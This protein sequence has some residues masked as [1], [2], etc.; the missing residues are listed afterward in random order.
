MELIVSV[1][2]S[3][4]LIFVSSPGNPNEPRLR[5]HGRRDIDFAFHKKR[6]IVA[7][8]WRGR[9]RVHG[10]NLA[11]EDKKVRTK[12]A[13]AKKEVVERGQGAS[14]SR[15]SIHRGMRAEVRYERKSIKARSTHAW[16]KL[17]GHESDMASKGRRDGS[18]EWRERCWLNTYIYSGPG[19]IR[20]NTG[21]QRKREEKG[22]KRKKMV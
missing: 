8:N 6:S 7:T 14:W 4:F 10:G 18:E 11:E 3:S 19:A 13:K 22:R 12:G 5:Y 15:G 20:N 17:S 1:F 16:R 2:I 21:D 9:S